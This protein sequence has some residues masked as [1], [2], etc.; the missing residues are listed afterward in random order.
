MKTEAL[1]EAILFYK[2]S[3]MSVAEIARMLG[4]SA[5]VVEDALV[6]MRERLQ[7]R[8]IRLVRAGETVAL[9]TAPDAAKLI[10][11]LRK[12]ELSGEIG[13]ATL[14]TLTTVLYRAPVSKS[15]I[16]Y[17]RGVNSSFSLRAL[18]VRGLIERKKSEEGGRGFV[19]A[20]T[21]GVLAHLGA[22]SI[23]E[24]PDYKKVREEVERF[25]KEFSSN[26]GYPP[27][28]DGHQA[29]TSG[30]HVAFEEAENENA[31]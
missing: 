20:P 19:Y 15:E 23:E 9:A 26:E 25:R 10:E 2:A 8:G 28:A 12:E 3:P 1:I 22:G 30:E 31:E 11:A 24:L 18:L 27:E 5:D 16:D 4:K 21:I 14:E 17:V 6:A 7:D 29:Q 13:K